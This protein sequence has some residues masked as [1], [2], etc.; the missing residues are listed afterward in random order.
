MDTK[1]ARTGRAIKDRYL[2]DDY[3]GV[4]IIRKRKT[5]ITHHITFQKNDLVVLIT[6]IP[7]VTIPDIAN[8]VNIIFL[9]PFLLQ[10]ARYE[11]IRII[12]PQRVVFHP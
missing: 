7:M 4:T 12:L 6:P 5:T 9:P 3:S 8:I 11:L 1:I 2:S 10:V